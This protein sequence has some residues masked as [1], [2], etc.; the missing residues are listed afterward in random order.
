[1]GK[2]YDVAVAAIQ[3][4]ILH[5]RFGLQLGPAQFDL[6]EVGQNAGREHQG[7]VPGRRFP[8]LQCLGGWLPAVAGGLGEGAPVGPR[9][10]GTSPGV[11]ARR[12]RAHGVAL[13]GPECAG[14]VWGRRGVGQALAAPAGA[15]LNEL[16]SAVA[17]LT[18]VVPTQF[19]Y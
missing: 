10:E 1:M 13:A 4:P 14:L 15:T 11:S 17:R 5:R 12:P 9:S 16:V 7:R 18:V 2:L 3:Q 19:H 8:Q 6:A